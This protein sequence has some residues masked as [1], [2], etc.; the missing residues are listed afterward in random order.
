MLVWEQI[1]CSQLGSL[2]RHFRDNVLRA[3]DLESETVESRSRNGGPFTLT[4]KRNRTSSGLG[5]YEFM[6]RVVCALHVSPLLKS[7]LSIY[8][9]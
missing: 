1:S 8:F 4:Y 7:P 6:S 9:R 2:K 3:N 5:G